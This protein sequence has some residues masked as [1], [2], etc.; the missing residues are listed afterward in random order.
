M[1]MTPEFKKKIITGV[2]ISIIAIG[3]SYLI[4]RKK[5]NAYIVKKVYGK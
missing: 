5:I 1:N 4:F 3:S 2:A